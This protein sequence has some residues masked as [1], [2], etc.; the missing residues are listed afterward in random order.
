MQY[1]KKNERW[2]E[3]GGGGETLRKVCKHRVWWCDTF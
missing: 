1:V 3:K 2:K